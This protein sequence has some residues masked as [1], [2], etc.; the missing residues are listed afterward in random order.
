LSRYAWL[1]RNI[2]ISHHECPRI[3][4]GFGKE[5]SPST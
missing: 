5:T 1:D 3:F 2:A 4:E